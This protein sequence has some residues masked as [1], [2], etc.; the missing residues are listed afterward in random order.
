MVKFSEIPTTHSS[1][2]ELWSDE[3]LVIE[4]IANKFLSLGV[5][6]WGQS[7]EQREEATNEYLRAAGFDLDQDR[8]AAALWLQQVLAKM[9]RGRFEDEAA[10][11]RSAIE[12][13]RAA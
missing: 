11:L 2:P 13:R 8:A 6:H 3:P 10:H 4:Q 9:P 5:Q 12:H 7:I 1:D